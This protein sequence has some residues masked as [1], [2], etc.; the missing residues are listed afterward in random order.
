MFYY[1][2]NSDLGPQVS[3]TEASLEGIAEKSRE[4]ARSEQ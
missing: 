1:C 2:E 4:S 3:S